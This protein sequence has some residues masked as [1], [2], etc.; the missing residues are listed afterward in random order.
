MNNR[1]DSGEN[2]MKRIAIG[3]L[4]ALIVPACMH[5]TQNEARWDHLD[6]R[7]VILM[8]GYERV[9]HSSEE[10]PQLKSARGTPKRCR[11]KDGRLIDEN[12]VYQNGPETRFALCSCV[13]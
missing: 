8:D 6:G 2:P 13:D 11:V 4:M 9:V 12:G 3:V 10:C 5:K 1:W 7:M